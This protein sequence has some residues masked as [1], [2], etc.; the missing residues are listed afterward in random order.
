[1]APAVVSDRVL[2]MVAVSTREAE[3]QAPSSS[4]H[5]IVKG[6]VAAGYLTDDS[7]YSLGPAVG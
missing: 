7:T 1:M 4:V 6:L 5:Y 2:T 3:Q